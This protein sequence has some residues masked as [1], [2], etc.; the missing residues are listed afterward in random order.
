MSTVSKSVIN[1]MLV[2]KFLKEHPDYYEEMEKHRI[3]YYATHDNNGDTYTK[4]VMREIYDELGIIPEEKNMYTAFIDL[5]EE[6]HG[7]EGKNI[8]EVGGG[9]LPRL[10][11]R[12]HTLQHKG[13]I[14]I[15]DPRIGKDIEGEDRF[16]LIREPFTRKTELDG[17]DLLIGLMPC[18]G[19]EPLIDQAVEKKIDFLLWL[20]EGGPHGDCYDYFEDEREWLG[21]TIYTASRGVKDSRMGKLMEKMLP[22]YSHYPIIY[23]QREK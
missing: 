3:N 2:S 20:C 7:Y 13:T 18:K 23:N 11:K 12:I 19:A 15:Y 4:D 8:V 5:L 16:T 1:S 21:S 14:T 10:G 9:I 17:C 6:T 22:Q